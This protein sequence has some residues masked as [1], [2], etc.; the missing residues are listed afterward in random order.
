MRCFN[1]FFLPFL[2][3]FS[4]SFQ[5]VPTFS[6]ALK[7]V[8]RVNNPGCW[9]HFVSKIETSKKEKKKIR[10]DLYFRFNSKSSKLNFHYWIE[11]KKSNLLVSTRLTISSFI[12]SQPLDQLLVKIIVNHNY[13][14]CNESNVSN[15][16]TGWINDDREKKK[17][18]KRRIHRIVGKLTRR[19]IVH[20]FSVRLASPL[21]FTRLSLAAL[22]YY[23]VISRFT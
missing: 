14:T 1:K 17:K 18:K 4:S 12:Y 22:R 6:K 16:Q 11:K 9:S 10:F 20:W 3:F 13:S 23:V 8:M 7:R 21:F 19:A 2:S 5:R 15:Q